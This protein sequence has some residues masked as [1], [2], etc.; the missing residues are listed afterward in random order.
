MPEAK[1]PTSKQAPGAAEKP[2]AG[3]DTDGS[4]SAASSPAMP[5][6]PRDSFRPI[7]ADRVL[8]RFDAFVARPRVRAGVGIVLV[9][10]RGEARSFSPH[11]WPTL[12]E[13]VWAGSGSLYEVDMGLHHTEVALQLP[14][15]EDAFAF[16]VRAHVEWQVVDAIQ[17]VRDNIRDVRVILASLLYW[18][19]ADQT[20]SV[21]VARPAEAETKA[22]KALNGLDLAGRYGLRVGI[23]LEFRTDEPSVG[24]ATARREAEHEL[25]I[26]MLKQKV[27]EA[28]ERHNNVLISARLEMYRG[29]ITRGDFDQFALQLAQRPEDVASVVQLMRDERDERLRQVTDFVLQMLNSGAIERWEIDDQVRTALNWLKESTENIIGSS[30]QDRTTAAPAGGAWSSG[31]ELPGGAEL[32]RADKPG[33]DTSQDPPPRSDSNS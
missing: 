9:N 15:R 7:L 23:I 24:H 28:Q 5:A 10:V 26:E 11:Q 31:V 30:G 21:P 3:R 1:R 4:V 29:I 6:E 12:G 2:H 25:E 32:P 17:V 19:L 33:Q 27:R 18:V 16:P 22:Q 13:L 8:R 14:A 20:R